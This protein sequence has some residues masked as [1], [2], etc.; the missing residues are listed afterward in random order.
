MRTTGNYPRRKPRMQL[1]GALR[2]M[3]QR[4]LFSSPAVTRSSPHVRDG[5]NIQGVWNSFVIASLPAL[6]LGTWN[7]GLQINLAKERLGDF[8]NSGWREMVMASLGFGHDFSSVADCLVLGLLWYLPVFFLALGV[9]AFWEALFATTRHKPLGEGVLLTPWLFS[10]MLPAGVPLAQAALGISFG[11]V[12]GKLIYGGSG[13]YLVSPALLGVVF[14][15][16]AYPAVFTSGGGLVPLPGYEQPAVLELMLAEGGL[17]VVSTVGY[18][19]WHVFA[20]AHPGAMGTTSALAILLG[21]AYLLWV[22]AASWRVM[23]GALLGLVSAVTVFNLAPGDS[24]VFALPWYW[25]AMLGSFA[26]SVVFIATDPVAGAMTNAGRWGYGV[27][28]GVL[29]VLIRNTNPSF[30]DG[31]L[32]AILLASLFSPLIDYLV[33]ESNIRRRRRRLRGA[34]DES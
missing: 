19:G 17:S 18:S 34:T 6:L 23:L 5:N 8:E 7:L 14:L 13:R 12:V 2:L 22:G 15:L 20:G 25:H 27:M 16:I 26:F 4:F 1:P 11:V 3:A 28:V 33:I 10:L 31:V 32:F 29:T 24:P 30:S 21:A 9:S